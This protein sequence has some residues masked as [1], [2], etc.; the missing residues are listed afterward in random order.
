MDP[1]PSGI[2]MSTYDLFV[3]YIA[4]GS[5][6][7]IKEIHVNKFHEMI[8][9]CGVD[10]LKKTV[11]IHGLKLKG[12]FKVCEDYILAKAKQRNVNKDWKGGSQV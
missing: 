5:L 8:G 10:R 6:T 1:F 9:H 11:N 7:A 12:E 2:K 3:A 4:K